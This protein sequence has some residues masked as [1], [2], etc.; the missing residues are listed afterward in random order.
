MCTKQLKLEPNWTVSTSTDSA[1]AKPLHVWL[2]VRASIRNW[3]EQKSRQTG[4]P[5]LGNGTGLGDSR[6]R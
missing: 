6:S 1:S 5:V 4:A 3:I 2:A